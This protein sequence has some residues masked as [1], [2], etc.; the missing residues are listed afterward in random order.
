MT[1]TKNIFIRDSENIVA[2]LKHRDTIRFNISKYDTA[3]EKGVQRY[4]NLELARER[5]SW[6]KGTA[7]NHLHEY[8]IEFE[9]NSTRNGAQV[10]WCRNATEAIGSIKTILLEN[11][12]SLLVKSKSMTTEEIDFNEQI[13][14]IGVET[15]E[16]DLGEY[17][18]QLAGEKPYHI[19]TPAMHKSRHDIADLFHEKFNTPPGSDPQF[20]TA[21][22]REKLRQK[23]RTADVGV[24]GANFLVADVGGIGLT[25]NEGNGLMTVSFPKIH[26]VIAG[27]EKIIPSMNDLGLLWPLLATRGTGQQISAYNSLVTGPRKENEAD[28]PEKMFVLLLDNGRT[29]LYQYDDRYEALKCIRCGACLNVCPI[30][31]NVGGHTYNATYSGPIGSVITP[32]YKGEKEYNHLSFACTVCGKCTETCPVKIPLHNQLLLNRR[33]AVENGGDFLW[34]NGIKAFAYTFSKRKRLDAVD[35][36]MKNAALLLAKN[37]L[38]P[39]KSMPKVAERSFSKQ[40]KSKK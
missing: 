7:I 14:K 21:Y 29:N 36:K 32:F 25:E 40:W 19:L 26:I 9:K 16:T 39:G 12:A 34:N 10:I 18:V 11:Q 31:K 13:E 1:D 15:L 38:G 4:S 24:T 22:V 27:I 35:G 8:L 5:A 30:Y 23:F 17:I 28:G 2:N 37:V 33:D 3:V 20:L 6:I